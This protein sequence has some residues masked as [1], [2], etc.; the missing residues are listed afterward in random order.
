MKNTIKTWVTVVLLMVGAFFLYQYMSRV[1]VPVVRA[2]GTVSGTYSLESILTLGKPYKCAF[3]K[4]DGVSKISATFYTNTPDVYADFTIQTNTLENQRFNSFFLIKDKTTYTW[5]S[6]SNL[7]YKTPVVKSAFKNA[8]PREQAQ[9]VG[10]QD[11][12]PYE[13]ELLD[14]VDSSLFIVPT[15][16]TF[17]DLK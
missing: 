3:E 7:G 5:T 13:C 11:K 10:I 12:M 4:E 15:P 6:F 17:S 2:D 9:L 16:I 14:Q 1:E 8:T